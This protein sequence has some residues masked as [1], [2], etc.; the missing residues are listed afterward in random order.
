[1]NSI[2]ELDNFI[3]KAITQGKV[4]L[5]GTD[6]EYPGCPHCGDGGYARCSCEK[7]GCL[8]GME[9][10]DDKMFYTCPWCGNTGEME[11]ADSI[12]VSGGGY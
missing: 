2:D 8:G 3:G 7:I 4:N 5:S 9:K 10:K 11:F 1:V 6:S 12:D